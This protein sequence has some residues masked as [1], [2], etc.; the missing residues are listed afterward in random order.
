MIAEIAEGRR[1]AAERREM[2]ERI[3]SGT[4]IPMG[5][6]PKFI[7]QSARHVIHDLPAGL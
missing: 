3:S 4:P 1:P 6:Y 5:N 2:L 7:Q